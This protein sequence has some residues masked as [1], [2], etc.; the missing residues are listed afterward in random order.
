MTAPQPSSAGPA[1]PPRSPA[2]AWLYVEEGRAV[3]RIRLDGAA[4]GPWTIGASPECTITIAGRGLQA[5]HAEIRRLAGDFRLVPR[6][7]TPLWVSD[8]PV[9]SAVALAHCDRVRLADATLV[10]VRPPADNRTHHK[11]YVVVRRADGFVIHWA[12][13]H[14][15]FWVGRTHGDLLVMDDTLAGRHFL[16]ESWTPDLIYIFNERETAPVHLYG[17]ALK[18]GCRRVW[19]GGVV[20]AGGTRFAVYGRPRE[21]AVSP[22]WLAQTGLAQEGLAQE[23]PR[24]FH[25][26][27]RR[28]PPQQS[29]NEMHTLIVGA[30][31]PSPARPRDEAI[32]R[33]TALE[34]VLE[35]ARFEEPAPVPRHDQPTSE[36][37]LSA[38]EDALREVGAIPAGPRPSR[39]PHNAPSPP[40]PDPDR[41][42]KQLL[43]TA[44]VPS[45]VPA[46]PAPSQ[47]TMQME[48]PALEAFLPARDDALRASAPPAADAPARVA[49]PYL[50]G[51]RAALADEARKAAEA[52][53]Y[54]PK[55]GKKDLSLTAQM[56]ARKTD[57]RY[58]P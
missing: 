4:Q 46:P 55:A 34:A 41:A 26:A 21:A 14:A 51:D 25:A 52:E 7:A 29:M 5:V 48:R 31:P 42:R 8:R 12:A 38:I 44:Y 1:A 50:H 53:R 30:G 19:N 10:F 54:A 35:A 24:T 13:Q 40:E 23:G 36:V 20:A 33:E 37:P 2:E 18:R 27:T 3:H 43:E 28:D 58:R 32:T 45:P 15:R 11:T 9:T 17:D 16:V 6:V 22:P 56:R 49:S 39:S 57:D 47:L